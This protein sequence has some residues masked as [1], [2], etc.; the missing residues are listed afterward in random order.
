MIY[1]LRRNNEI[2]GYLREE[3]GSAYYSRDLYGWTGTEILHDTKE[4][5][6]NFKD[7]NAQRIF[8]NDFLNFNHKISGLDSIYMVTKDNENIYLKG[9]NNDEEKPIELINSRT[10]SVKKIGFLEEI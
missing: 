10:Y 8:I 6:T 9:Y 1:R 7:K 2:V 5:S 4:P 3:A